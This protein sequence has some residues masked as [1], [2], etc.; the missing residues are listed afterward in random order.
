M[1]SLRKHMKTHEKP[2]TKPFPCDIC[3]ESFDL[4]T[5][6]E[7]HMVSHMGENP[8]TCPTCL[9]KFD[10]VLNL[11]EHAKTH[12]EEELFICDGCG[13]SFNSGEDLESHRKVHGKALEPAQFPCTICQKMFK[14]KFR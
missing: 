2:E 3:E 6:F 14:F 5:E 1:P 7:T 11:L 8:F 13:R 12:E 4:S 9:L 10:T